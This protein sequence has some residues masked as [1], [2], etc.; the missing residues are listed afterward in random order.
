MKTFPHDWSHSEYLNPGVVR[1]ID[2]RLVRTVCE[3]GA[4]DG[5][6]TV[7]L[8]RHFDADVHAF[9][10][11]PDM[12]PRARA[13]IAAHPQAGRIR[14]CAKAV[15]DSAGRIPFFPVVRTTTADGSV[16]DN[17]GASSCFRARHDYHRSY[18]QTTTEVEAIRLDDYCA[19]EGVESFDLLCMDIQGAAL[20]A[21]RGLGDRLRQVRYIIAELEN[22]PL[23]EGQDLFPE[24][25]AFLAAQGFRVA[26]AVT[27]DDW[28]KDY[29]FIARPSRLSGPAK[30]RERIARLCPW[31]G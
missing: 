31:Q 2:A 6:D 7:D 8:R 27:R 20:R 28:F 26:A 22:R 17:P 15:W 1:M 5:S 18:E 4:H 21:L 19:A 11:H 13:C 29:L 24:V 30:W 9:E 25:R 16:I 23:Y 10:C 12:V 14:L 3:L